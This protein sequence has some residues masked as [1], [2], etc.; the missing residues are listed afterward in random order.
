MNEAEYA[1]FTSPANAVKGEQRSVVD[2]IQA[3]HR[4]ASALDNVLERILADLNGF[5]ADGVT[6]SGSAPSCGIVADADNLAQRLNALITTAERIKDR[7]S[8]DK[9]TEMSQAPSMDRRAY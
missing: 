3:S 5:G 9:V 1:K 6:A 4:F 2:S 7:L 8:P